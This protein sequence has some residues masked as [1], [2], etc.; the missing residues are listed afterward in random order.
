MQSEPHLGTR[1]GNNETARQMPDTPT[2]G[3]KRKTAV[4]FQFQPDPTNEQGRYAPPLERGWYSGSAHR[5]YREA[6]PGSRGPSNCGY[7]AG[8]ILSSGEYARADPL[9]YEPS[10]TAPCASRE[11]KTPRL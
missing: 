2:F 4:R 10:A 9:D 11:T 7:I 5:H 6:K 3:E 8:P 1:L